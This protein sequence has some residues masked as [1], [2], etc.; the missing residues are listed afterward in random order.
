MFRKVLDGVGKRGGDR[1]GPAAASAPPPPLPSPTSA[2]VAAHSAPP[3]DIET[4]FQNAQRLLGQVRSQQV[5]SAPVTGGQA[6]GLYTH[7]GSRVTRSCA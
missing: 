5:N 3:D 6:P 2:P 7:C 1:G 4:L